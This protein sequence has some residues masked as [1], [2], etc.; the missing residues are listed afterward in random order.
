MS[1]K[2]YEGFFVTIEG[3]EGCGKTTLAY[4][5]TL[6]LKGRGYPVV[7]T[8]EP[9]GSVLSEHL[10]TLLLNPHTE[11]AISEKAELLLFLA[12]RAQHMEELITPALY[13]GKIVICERFHD[14]TIVYQGC[15]RS[16]GMHYVENLCLQVTQWPDFTLLLDIDP[17][18]GRHRLQIAERKPD[19]LEK[20]KLQ[21]HQEVRQGF[22]H[23]ADEHSE[24]IAVI[25]ATLPSK[26]VLEAALL[27]L[28]SHLMTRKP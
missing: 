20:E 18:E 15:A 4:L 2:P 19:R 16:L 5:L 9:G 22:L 11:Y 23:L 7:Q 8:R 25:D 6:E 17:Q 1:H 26:E 12:A 21:F 27:V 28:E 3:G 13:Q 10:R 24:R 14:S